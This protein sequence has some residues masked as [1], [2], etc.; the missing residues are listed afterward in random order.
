MMSFLATFMAGAMFLAARTTTAVEPPP[1]SYICV[2]METGMVLMEQNADIQ[3]PPASML[4]LM[5]MLLVEEGAL[6]GKWR[7]DQQIRVSKLAQGMGGTQAFL[8]EGESWPLEKLMCAI[9]VLSANDASVAV[10]EGL[11]G[12]VENCLNAMNTRAGEL[13]MRNTHFHSVNGLPPDDKVSFDQTTARE[14]AILG[15]AVLQH[16][17]VLRWTSMKQFALRPTDTPKANTN[18]LLDQCPG[19]DG[20]KTG[21]IRASGFCLTATALRDDIRLIAVVMGSDKTGRFTHTHS[22]LEQGFKM[23]RRVQPV[24]KGMVIGK[25]IPVNESMD[26][27]V[28]LLARDPIT[29]TV[30]DTD[31]QNLALE[32]TA[33]TSLQA[34]VSAN[35]ENGQVRLLLGDRELGKS[36]LLID[37]TVEKVRLTDYGVGCM[38]RKE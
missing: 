1:V 23:I 5:Q 9:A 14:M 10:A 27:E 7:Y 3:R 32:I 26:E 13:G 11:W 6:A 16:P 25:P 29:V 36:P 17:N 38:G 35:S 34:P 2:E 28:R 37:R 15:R 24:Q 12:S 20:L 33:P 22:L 31:V 21:Y 30:R 8:K 4:K 18:K 19:C